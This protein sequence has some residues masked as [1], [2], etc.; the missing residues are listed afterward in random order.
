MSR[1]ETKALK[2]IEYFFNA[3]NTRKGLTL[4]QK[5]FLSD[6]LYELYRRER[7][8]FALTVAILALIN[9]DGIGKLA[10]TFSR[11]LDNVLLRRDLVEL[12][13][14]LSSVADYRISFP[15]A[16]DNPYL[17]KEAAE[18]IKDIFAKYQKEIVQILDKI[19]ENP[20]EDLCTIMSCCN[21]ESVCF[22]RILEDEGIPKTISF[23]DKTSTGLIIKHELPL[24]I[25][26]AQLAK[27]LSP[28]SPRTLLMLRRR[29]HREIAMYKRYLELIA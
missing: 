8:N 9:Q 5:V 2:E 29:L 27:N 17:S 15:E 16:F 21:D 19:N 23:G 26:V 13:K 12:D 7:Y 24:E 22:S 11:R 3:S 25:I 14:V 4:Q 6:S 18:T 1:E 28:Y 10:F 20:E